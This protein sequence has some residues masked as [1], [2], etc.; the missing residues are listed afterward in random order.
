[1][2]AGSPP[3]VEAPTCPK[4]DPELLKP[5]AYADP[6]LTCDIVM[7]GGV[8]SGIVYPRAAAQLARRYHFRKVGGTSAGAIAAVGVA[9]AEFRR[10][11]QAG[12]AD[13]GE[14]FVRLARIPDEL[15]KQD[16]S[17][18][19]KLLRLFEPQ[20][21]TRSL[22]ELVT[23]FTKRPGQVPFWKILAAL[24]TLRQRLLL[25]AVATVLILAA[26]IVALFVFS[27]PTWVIALLMIVPVA[28]VL[29]TVLVVV[30]GAVTDAKR[31]IPDA[32]QHNHFGI[33]TLGTEPGST[34]SDDGTALTP[35]LHDQ[36]QTIAGLD[37]DDPLTFGRLWGGDIAGACPVH[38]Y[39]CPH[40]LNDRER[41][42]SLRS[43]YE[44]RLIDLQL[45]TTNLTTGRPLRLPVGEYVDGDLKDGGGLMFVEDELAAFFPGPVIEHLRLRSSR[46]DPTTQARLVEEVARLRGV[47]QD[48]PDAGS[49]RY[50]PLN[51][52]LPV[53]VACRLS[54]SF[55]GL[56]SALPF[57]QLDY[58]R[59]GGSAPG[60]LIRVWYS[61]GGITSN[62]PV[63]LFDAPLPT[64]PTFAFN[65]TSFEEG[66]SPDPKHPERS[67]EVTTDVTKKSLQ[68]WREIET[69]P[70]FIVGI[71][72]AMQNWR[73]ST[74]AA[75]PGY[76]ERVVHI[77]LDHGEG[78]LNLAMKA[79]KIGELADRGSCAG[80]LAVEAFSGPISRAP[81]K[82][83]VWHNHRWI[84][85]RVLFALH[86][87]LLRD[88]QRALAEPIDA[89]SLSYPD[90]WKR[91]GPHYRFRAESRRDEA[92]K[93]LAAY[94]C[95]IAK[96]S[97]PVADDRL[98]RPTPDLRFVPP[99]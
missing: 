88:V 85:L 92:Q 12:Q 19:V 64:R 65:L 7:K 61:D 81:S 32:L 58:E 46:P 40:G 91:N 2:D 14:G 43:D 24:P 95:L 15:A 67:V 63:H 55:P 34:V 23:A 62:F 99:A 28:A 59:R 97:P 79:E 4:S 31:T 84:R 98:P 22:F 35:W 69:V 38:G 11:S 45:V 41:R 36:I 56:L 8:T 30:R 66:E 76:R 82:Q 21:A 26:A 27:L 80:R 54:L 5:G 72:D 75:L 78:G 94:L 9:A 73:D 33:C 53:I 71:K 51:E 42:D 25:G 48:A 68:R 77:K 70:Q 87:R 6:P 50:L 60:R 44:C 37:H 49:L 29:M 89:V 93:M 52:E 3:A 10:R 17:G 83:D 20:R 39:R 86:D 13:A 96:A 47:G 1:M 18:Q 57:W 90:L 16:A 74:H